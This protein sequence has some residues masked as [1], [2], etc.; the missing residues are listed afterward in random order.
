MRK[1]ELVAAWALA[2]ALH[3]TGYRKV[4]PSETLG[5][6]ICNFI[7]TNTS[8]KNQHYSNI[9]QPSPYICGGA[10]TRAESML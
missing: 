8:K 9:E 3:D 4:V 10:A 7:C 2:W 5:L 1:P 6:E